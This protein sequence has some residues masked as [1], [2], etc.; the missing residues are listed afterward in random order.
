[1]KGDA[2]VKV[3]SENPF[4]PN[5]SHWN[6]DLQFQSQAPDTCHIIRINSKNG[7]SWFHSR[8][9]DPDNEIRGTGEDLLG[10]DFV[11]NSETHIRLII[12]GDPDWL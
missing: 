10:L 6:Y 7:G 11:Q 5:E 2:M 1:M 4:V 9:A 8:R 3:T 12:I